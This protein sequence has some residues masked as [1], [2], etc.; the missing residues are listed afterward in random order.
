MNDF[1][2]SVNDFNKRKTN[3]VYDSSRLDSIETPL[4]RQNNQTYRS[5]QVD[6][7][8]QYLKSNNAFGNQS[9]S[10]DDHEGGRPPISM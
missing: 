8:E 9:D 4:L 2:D 5:G 10:D 3:K 6:I 1:I 7:F